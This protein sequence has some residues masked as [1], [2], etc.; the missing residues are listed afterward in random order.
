MRQV[1][2]PP[3]KAFHHFPLLLQ[4]RFY[5]YSAFT[6]D[7]GEGASLLLISRPDYVSILRRTF[8]KEM[9]DTVS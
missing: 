4:S 2:I 7:S 3:G 1:T 8:E 9:T 6:E 5:G